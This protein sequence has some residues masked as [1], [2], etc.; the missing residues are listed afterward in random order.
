M[1]PQAPPPMTEKELD[2]MV[3]DACDLLGWARYHTFSSYRSP[4]GFP[5]LVLVRERVIYAELKSAKGFV[6]ARQQRWLDLLTNAGQEVYVWRPGQL[7]EI[8]EILR[9]KGGWNDDG[10]TATD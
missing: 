9:R 8:I 5:D 6:T 7:K 2:A 1:L 3:R 4:S 10:S